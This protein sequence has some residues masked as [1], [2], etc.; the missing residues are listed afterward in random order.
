MFENIFIGLMVVVA[1]VGA[2]FG[3]RLEYGWPGKDETQE[4]AAAEGEEPAAGGAG[5]KPAEN[6]ADGV[7]KGRKLAADRADGVNKGRKLA[8]DRTDGA[9]RG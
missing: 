7:N 1:M 3:W 6:R 2:Y 8:A 9:N 4:P 5:K